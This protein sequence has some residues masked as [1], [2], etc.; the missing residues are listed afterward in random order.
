MLELQQISTSEAPPSHETWDLADLGRAMF[1]EWGRYRT[2]QNTGIQGMDM[3]MPL[4][5]LAFPLHDPPEFAAGSEH[6]F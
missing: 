2:F 3:K 1:V 5:R 4:F 6:N